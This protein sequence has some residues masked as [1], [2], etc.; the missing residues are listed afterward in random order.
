MDHDTPQRVA[1]AH[2]KVSIGYHSDMSKKIEGG[3]SV[4]TS[5]ITEWYGQ[6]NPN[7]KG[8]LA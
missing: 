8:K 5:V 7:L 2:G 6:L 4:L 1:N 3:H